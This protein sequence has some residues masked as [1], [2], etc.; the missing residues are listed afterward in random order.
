M[1]FD[2]DTA[3][4]IGLPTGVTGVAI[5][6]VAVG[7]VLAGAF[8]LLKGY[9]RD[10]LERL[11]GWAR[12]RGLE[13]VA[14]ASEDVVATFVGVVEGTQVEVAVT[15][16]ARGFGV[17]LPSRLTTIAVGDAV[18][19][20]QCEV[21]PATWV[22]DRDGGKAV[23][24]VPSGDALFDERWST[25]GGADAVGRLL[26]HKVR[27]R[28]LAGDADGLVVELSQTAVAIPMPGV[29]SDAQELERRLTLA[30]DLHAAAVS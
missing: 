18:A 16:V 3:A 30:L 12:A 17:D 20:P 26:S 15:R 4:P 28:L 27:S 19:S 11:A 1:I 5:A 21:Q 8:A 7:A 22:M 23:A 29:C 13:Y 6:A 24:P 2:A 14:P 25:R 10:P 9:G